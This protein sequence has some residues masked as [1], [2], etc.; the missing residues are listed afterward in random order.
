MTSYQKENIQQLAQDIMRYK[1]AYYAGKPEVSD[2]VFD[3]L[4]EKLRSL[5]PQHPALI[6]VGTQVTEGKDKIAHDKPM[7][8]L[9]KT[10]KLED[11]IS[12]AG[13]DELVGSWK[14]DGNSL[15]L[16]YREGKLVQAKTR[17][18]GRLGE[19]VTEKAKWVAD[20]VPELSGPFDVEIRGELYCS[21][22]QFQKL[23]TTML[24]RELERPSNP[25]NIVAGLLGRKSHY[26]LTRYFNFFAFETISQDELLQFDSEWLS[27]QWLKKEGFALPE[28][29]KLKNKKDVSS[30][31]DAV[32]EVM[33]QAEIGLD[34]AVF[35]LNDRNRHEE[36]G[37]T[38][39]HPRY[40]MS[41]KWQGDTATSKIK[42]I[43]W[44]TSRRGVVTP[45][46]VVE[47][48]ELSG[49][50][51]TNVTL[52]NALH[53]TTYNL[54]PG[55]EIE[56]V[57]SGEVIP[58][59]LQV[60]QSVPGE[61]AWPKACPSCGTE[62]EYDGV[63]LKCMNKVD[64]PA[65]K[66]GTI[67]N[68]IRSVQIDDLSEKR[69]NALL[70][71]GLVDGIPDLYRLSFD[72]FLSLPLTKD[73]MAKKLFDNI[74]S[75]K[76]VDL[77]RF[78]LGLGIEGMGLSSWEKLT[79][80]G[81]DLAKLR[82]MGVDE[83]QAIDGFAEKTAEQVVTGIAERTNLIDQLL[84]LGLTPKV[85]SGTKIAASA[86]GVL[87]GKTLVV[88]GTLSRPRAAV[89]QDIKAAGGKLS[90]AVSSKTFALITNDETSNSSKF[91]KA[92]SLGI[93]IWNEDELLRKIGGGS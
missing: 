50:K 4:E 45:V 23:V 44:A 28:P 48:V 21:A 9:Q 61:A 80:L 55:D 91:K 24:A 68:W 71:T 77:A 38:S 75:S 33:T 52:H 78:M 92:Q 36:L 47:P 87:L 54:K 63:R 88:T 37:E 93:P 16:I 19:D 32:S 41:F 13:E 18:N 90:G 70:E 49:A 39:H 76:N 31:L 59:F 62:L 14:I 73:K 60:T 51:I 58:K 53:V 26:D 12:W 56:L 8:S 11:L 66:Q 74:Q 1:E 67:L 57:R 89:E 85:E 7:L 40:K 65:Q 22:S 6:A 10:Y 46:A 42:Q 82:E 30:Y 25:R 27:F 69:L 86:E 84:E 3:E 2:N 35:V 5:A 83:L 43:G 20:I 17:G 81:F 64:C 29:S 15:S 79:N 34:G 72:D